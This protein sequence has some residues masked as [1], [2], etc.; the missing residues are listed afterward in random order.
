MPKP[1]PFEAVRFHAS[2]ELLPLRRR[3]VATIFLNHKHQPRSRDPR[4]FGRDPFKLTLRPYVQIQVGQDHGTFLEALHPLDHKC[5][6]GVVGGRGQ[7]GR[8]PDE[9]DASD[10]L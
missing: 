9:A 7:V 4:Q 2:S 8:G 6:I 10:G 1:P 5:D 3:E